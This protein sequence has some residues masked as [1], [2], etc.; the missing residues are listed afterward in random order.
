MPMIEKIVQTAKQA[1]N[2]I[3]DIHK[4]LACPAGAVFD[5]ASMTV[6]PWCRSISVDGKWVRR[7]LAELS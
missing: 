3:V 6:S 2:A 1:V 7:E 4:A 5:D